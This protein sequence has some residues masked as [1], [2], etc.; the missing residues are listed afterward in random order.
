[1]LH[2]RKPKPV[3][4]FAGLIWS[5]RTA[6]DKGLAAMEEVWG[7][8]DART[9]PV[10]FDFT[11]YYAD[12]MGVELHRQFVAF[13]KLADPSSLPDLKFSASQIEK[14]L[15]QE[16]RRR[17]NIDVGYLDYRRVVLASTKEG[18]H[19]IYLSGGIWADLTLTY[20]NGSF[21]A[22]P[23]TFLDF[24]RGTYDEFFLK[25]RESYKSRLREF[26]SLR[27]EMG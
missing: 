2:T 17:I 10:P 6:F 19:K 9:E 27:Q 1:M 14:K 3:K 18:T 21:S 5:D 26:G 23:W 15:C 22:L 20:E 12:E 25:I 16:G 13:K 4:V 8:S 7:P 24:R 11:D